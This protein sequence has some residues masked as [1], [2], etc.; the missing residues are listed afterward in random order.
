MSL[1]LLMVRGLCADLSL[2]EGMSVFCCTSPIKYRIST[3]WRV[4]K[5]WQLPLWYLCLE[6]CIEQALWGSGLPIRLSEMQHKWWVPCPTPA[7]P[8]QHSKY[9]KNPW[10]PMKRRKLATR[11]LWFF[12]NSGAC[13]AP[14]QSTWTPWKPAVKTYVRTATFQAEQACGLPK[15]SAKLRSYFSPLNV[16]VQLEFS[17]QVSRIEPALHV[18]WTAQFAFHVKNASPGWY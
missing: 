3:G 10:M 17:G 13:S 8:K 15:E 4:V 11:P 5:T 18:Q 1:Y 6:P 12:L 16:E 7:L 14:T 9:D 2:V